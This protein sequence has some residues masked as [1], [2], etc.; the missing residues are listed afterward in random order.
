M[1]DLVPR[2]ESLDW[3]AWLASCD[4]DQWAIDKE[5]WLV[6]PKS[7]CDYL[8]NEQVDPTLAPCL[9]APDASD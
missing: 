4:F 1:S 7:D 9:C 5:Q 6:D 2:A 3:L 8:K